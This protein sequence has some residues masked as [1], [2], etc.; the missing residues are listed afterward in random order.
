MGFTEAT[1]P[2]EGTSQQGGTSPHTTL[3]SLYESLVAPPAPPHW[4]A[5][6]PSRA[7]LYTRG[8]G[9]PRRGKSFHQIASF[10]TTA[11]L[12]LKYGTK[13]L[14]VADFASFSAAHP[15][16]YAANRKLLALA[17][18]DFRPALRYNSEWAK[19]TEVTHESTKA[20]TAMLYHCNMY[21]PDVMRLLGNNFTGEFRD[22][23]AI[24]QRIAHRVPPELLDRFKMIMTSG[25]PIEFNAETS[26]QNFLLHLSEGNHPSIAKNEAQVL[27]C[28]AKDIRH[29]YSFALPTYLA[30]FLPHLFVTPQH[31]LQRPGKDDRLIYDSS[32]RYTPEST[33][34][35]MMT[36]TATNGELRC[37]YG[38][39]LQ[40]VLIRAYNLRITYPDH[41]LCIHANDVAGAFRQLK[42]HPDCMPAFACI[43]ADFL[44]MQCGLAFG[45]DF[46]PSNWE[47][48]RRLAEI[49]ATD[50]FAD[51]SLRTKH[52]AYLDKLEWNP[53][54]GNPRT[55]FTQATADGINRGVLDDQGRPV[56]TPHR[57]FVDDDIYLDVYDIARIEQ[58]IAASIEAIFVLLGE[59]D[60]S[61]RRDPIS[62]SKLE[63]M[64]VAPVNI[65][66]GQRVNLRALTVEAA[67][68]MVAETKRELDKFA[69]HRK[70]FVVR[71]LATLAGKLTH[72]AQTA[73]WLK[74][75]MAQFYLTATRCL[76][77]NLRHLCVTY[78]SFRKALKLS[79]QQGTTDQ[80]RRSITFAQSTTA[81]KIHSCRFQH[82][83]SKE[84]RDTLDLIRS[85][86]NAS[87]I[88]TRSHIG[89][90][91]P[92]E[93]SGRAW[94]DSSLKAAGGYST[95]MKFWWYLEWPAE[96]REK[97]LSFV[98]N[99]KDGRLISINAL[100]YAGIIITYVAS[101]HFFLHNPRVNDPHPVALLTAD[102]TTAESWIV[103]ACMNSAIGRALGRVQCA[104]MIN[105][106]VGLN[107]AHISSEDNIVADEISRINR[108]SNADSYFRSLTQRFPELAGCRR[109]H[110]SS[111]LIS[112]IMAAIC[113][114]SF[115]DPVTASRRLLSDLGRTTS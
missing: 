28:M 4:H 48:I 19:I 70:V 29:N 35:G 115:A 88:H 25:C 71:D 6:L 8:F 13:Y 64:L 23:N 56:P 2:L 49:L 99:N 98:K 62:W 27:K 26:R 22:I 86:L 57:F 11:I 12:F 103:K 87:H 5:D 78:S 36:T 18:Y 32:K 60:L 37:E 24:V 113:Q 82:F 20:F 58:A 72:V 94:S 38:T 95:D 40:A 104:L 41:D 68:K 33:S 85:A 47:V 106:P 107:S 15:R 50:Y 83:I 77:V 51:T 9:R 73:P 55:P 10:S 74:H 39:V 54:L 112:M 108:A 111:E 105:N 31:L 89:H 66:L 61:K 53:T 3:V 79:K 17:A 101:T 75:L 80:D 1:I 96:I 43:V 21:L 110:P 91:I 84:L 44:F 45:T 34:I 76:K 114:Q 7:R 90:V 102:N 69:T 30:P 81:R 14:T 93:P 65:V 63:D 52:R 109:F 42:T 67:P 59:S 46:A 92:R 16:V 97:T 100:E